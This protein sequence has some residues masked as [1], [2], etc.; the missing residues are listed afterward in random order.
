MINDMLELPTQEL[1]TQG[2][3][4]LKCSNQIDVQSSLIETLPHERCARLLRNSK[5]PSKLPAIGRTVNV[6]FDEAQQK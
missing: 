3:L 5:L 4:W 6:H 2:H 1:P